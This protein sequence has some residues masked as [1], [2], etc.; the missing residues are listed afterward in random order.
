MLK[1]P[2]FLKHKLVIHLLSH[3]KNHALSGLLKPQVS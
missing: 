3:I 1:V 2:W